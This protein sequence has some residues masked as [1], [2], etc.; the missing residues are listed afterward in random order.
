MEFNHKE[1]VIPKE[2][3]T[4]NRYKGL[5]IDAK[6]LYGLCLDRADETD[7]IKAR[8]NYY[9]IPT[10]LFTDERYK[11]ITN[12]AKILYGLLLDRAKWDKEQDE[13]GDYYV[14]FKQEEAKKT[15]KIGKTSVIG[16]FQELEA[17][18]LITRKKS[19]MT[20]PH[21]IYVNMKPEKSE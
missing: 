14:T 18:H 12:K 3:F 16:S 21:R 15:L 1:I 17:A 6:I 13:Q 11:H 20:N 5:S 19:G 7:K 2:L 4:N 8:G 9:A 10:T